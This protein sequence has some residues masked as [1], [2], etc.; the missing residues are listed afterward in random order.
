MNVSVRD[1]EGAGKVLCIPLESE[2]DLAF[3]RFVV[4]AP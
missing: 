2:G 1:L 4:F 3:S